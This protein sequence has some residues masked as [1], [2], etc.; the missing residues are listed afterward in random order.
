MYV[1][2]VGSKFVLG[3]FF[4]FLQEGNQRGARLL[5]TSLNRI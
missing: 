4:A 5:R 1:H 2:N 3:L